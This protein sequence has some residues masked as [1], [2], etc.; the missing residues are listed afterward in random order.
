MRGADWAIE[1]AAK[2]IVIT[3]TDMAESRHKV[4]RKSRRLTAAQPAAV[5]GG[6]LCAE[7][8]GPLYHGEAV[9]QNRDRPPLDICADNLGR[10]EN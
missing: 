10:K 9:H 6:C 2:G 8:M 7:E 1:C 4:C 5:A 3:D